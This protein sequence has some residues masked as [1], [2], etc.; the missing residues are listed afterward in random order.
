VKHPPKH[1]EGAALL[2]VL[3]IV[4][5]MAVLAA[6]ALERLKIGTRLTA[7]GGAIEQ[8]RAYAMAAETVARFRIGDL[9]QRDAAKTTLVGNWAGQPTNFPI[10]GGLATARIDDGGNCFNLNGLV[11][12]AQDGVLIARPFAVAQFARLMT[13]LDVP[14]RDADTLANAT[15]DWIDSDVAPSPNGAEDAAYA[16]ARTPYLPANILMADTS[17]FRAVAGVT[18]A[19]YARL[20]PFLCALP[21]TDLTAINVNTLRR[22]QAP[23]LAAVVPTLDIARAAA[24]VEARPEGGWDSLATFWALPQ[25]A[26]NGADAGRGQIKLS[27]RWFNLALNV[28]LNGAELEEHALIDAA[29]KPAKL[30]RRSYGEPS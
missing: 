21:V 9:I 30:A 20:R 17:E 13:L 11:D 22:D 1:E 3:L 5:V 15:A 7:N 4:A 26:A 27:T 24:V 29:L 25:L 23:L 18:P 14:G 19:L 2:T 8:A 28:E 16:A 6:A 10:D 12:K